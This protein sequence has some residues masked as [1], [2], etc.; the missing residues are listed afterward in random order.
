VT[1][2][3]DDKDI[4]HATVSFHGGDP[5]DEYQMPMPAGVPAPDDL[6]T[7]DWGPPPFEVRD[8]GPLLAPDGTYTSTRRV[9]ERSGAVGDDPRDHL[10]VATFLS[11]MTGSGFR[12][13]SLDAWG[14]HADASIDHAVWF[15]R[16]IRTDDWLFFDLHALINAGG[17]STARGCL[18]S[19]DGTLVLSMAQELLIRPL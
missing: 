6:P 5:G 17:R 13:L 11:D 15:H 4:F 7:A 3:Q 2:S 1:L 18:Y 19:R 10:L 9:W 8:I 14:E 16:P 12:P